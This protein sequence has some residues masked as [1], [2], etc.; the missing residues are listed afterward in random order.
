MVAL[1]GGTGELPQ[2]EY[3]RLLEQVGFRPDVTW[4][5]L[6]AASSTHR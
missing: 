1:A 6:G 4:L 5:Q 3:A 2:Q